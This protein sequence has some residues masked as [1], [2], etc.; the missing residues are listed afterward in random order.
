MNFEELNSR[1][2]W[3]EK[4]SD[5]INQY[6]CFWKEFN[7]E[8][9]AFHLHICADTLYAVWMNEKLVCYG[10]YLAYPENKYYDT[11][12]LC[13]YSVSGKNVICILVYYQGVGT[14]C[15]AKGTPGLIYALTSNS[16]VISN[17]NTFVCCGSGFMQGPMPLISGQ[18]GPSFEYDA[19][20]EIDWIGLDCNY[21]GFQPAVQLA[22][23]TFL[24]S[25]LKKRPIDYLDKQTCSK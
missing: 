22:F 11:Y 10:G 25:D 12:D 2:L 17:E 5:E 15:Y 4:S 20:K 14:S 24:P 8:E 3:N 23:D 21:D 7:V 9:T 16:A 18:L 19:T 6:V 13:P 1:W